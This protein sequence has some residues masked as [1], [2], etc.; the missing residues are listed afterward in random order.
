MK[1]KEYYKQLINADIFNS[2]LEEGAYI[3]IYNLWRIS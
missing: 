2:G 1:I 3:L